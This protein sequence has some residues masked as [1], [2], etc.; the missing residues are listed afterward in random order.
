MEN[1]IRPMD[2]NNHDSAIDHSM[3]VLNVDLW[4]DDGSREVN[5]VRSSTGSP[6]ISSTTPFSYSTLNGGDPSMSPY[7]QHVLASSR[8]GSYPPAQTGPYVSDYQVQP[9]Y[10]QGTLHPRNLA[11]SFC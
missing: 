9:G 7:P 3:F 11:A 4:S 1:A 8:D 2:A 10:N 5:L 6:S